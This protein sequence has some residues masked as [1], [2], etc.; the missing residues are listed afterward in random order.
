MQHFEVL[1]LNGVLVLHPLP[2]YWH[3]DQVG[4]KTWGYLLAMAIFTSHD[5]NSI[6]T[7]IYQEL[8]VKNVGAYYLPTH[9]S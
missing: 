8:G 7:M 3:D 9:S 2:S 5:M 6:V 4:R 1:I